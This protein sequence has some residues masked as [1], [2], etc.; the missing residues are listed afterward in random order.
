MAAIKTLNIEFGTSFLLASV[1]MTDKTVTQVVC[2]YDD[3]GGASWAS[4]TLR[5]RDVEMEAYAE[6][7]VKAAVHAVMDE[8]TKE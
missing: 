2:V 6:G 7:V 5:E 4:E 1:T 3:D 8:I